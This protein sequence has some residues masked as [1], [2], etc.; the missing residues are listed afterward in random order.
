VVLFG[1]VCALGSL[2]LAGLGLFPPARPQT[3]QPPP[4]TQLPHTQTP[5]TQTL[6]TQAIVETTA[7]IASPLPQT[8]GGTFRDDFSDPTSGWE[9]SQDAEGSLDYDAGGY[10]IFIDRPQMMFWSTPGREYRNVSVEVDVEKIAGADDNYFGV[11]CRY[12]DENNFYLL[13]ISSD[14]YYGIEKY[15]EGSFVPGND[16]ATGYDQVI[17]Q[18]KTTNHLRADCIGDTLTLYANETRLATLED[19]EFAQGDIGLLARS[20]DLAGTNLLFDNFVAR[21][22]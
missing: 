10:R 8:G 20:T 2:L 21:Q 9:R 7:P 22:P 13:W 5:G 12:Q 15:K 16:T 6:E 11:L 18:G 1:G 4:E 19:R 3:G 17:H 14:G